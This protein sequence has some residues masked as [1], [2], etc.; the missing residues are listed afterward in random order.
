MYFSRLIERAFG[1]LCTCLVLPVV[2]DNL[3]R[4]KDMSPAD[5]QFVMA[6]KAVVYLVVVFLVL[7]AIG[8]VQTALSLRHLHRQLGAKVNG[9]D[10]FLFELGTESWATARRY[11]DT[12]YWVEVTMNGVD[13]DVY[14]VSNEAIHAFHKTFIGILVNDPRGNPVPMHEVTLVPIDYKREMKGLITALEY[15]P[16]LQKDAPPR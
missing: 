4:Q 11:R 6:M 16:S 14:I 15:L 3:L 9:A 12:S 13:Q 5:E 2:A 10:K 1:L 7:V 8:F